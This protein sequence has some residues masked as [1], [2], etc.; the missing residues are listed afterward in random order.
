[1]FLHML[2]DDINRSITYATGHHSLPPCS[3]RTTAP[4]SEKPRRSVMGI[5]GVCLCQVEDSNF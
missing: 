5:G 2:I 4:H 3:R 1:M